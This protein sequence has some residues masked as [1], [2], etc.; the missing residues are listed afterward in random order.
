M[1]FSLDSQTFTNTNIGHNTV[2]V[3]VVNSRSL[4]V[5]SKM[6]PQTIHSI[7][8]CSPHSVHNFNT[9]LNFSEFNLHLLEPFGN[10][11]RGSR[12]WRTHNG[13]MFSVSTA[14]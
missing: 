8:C 3:V 14:S 2:G 7:V 4:L 6:Q 12:R 9:V 13:T 10:V 11:S 1:H 5:V